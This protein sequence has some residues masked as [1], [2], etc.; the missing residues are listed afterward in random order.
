MMLK[1]GL[2]FGECRMPCPT[3]G[4]CVMHPVGAFAERLPVW[5]KVRHYGMACRS[6]GVKGL[7]LQLDEF[8][9]LFVGGFDLFGAL[10]YAL[11]QVRPA[12]TDVVDNEYISR[13]TYQNEGRAE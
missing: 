3:Q 13:E 5:E 4:E 7:L 8:A 11:D 12:A 1:R 2:P 9:F 6:G 10:P